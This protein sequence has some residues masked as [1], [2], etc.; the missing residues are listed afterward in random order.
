MISS[1]DVQLPLEELMPL[2][3][4]RLEMGQTV[5]FS[6]RGTSML[7]MLRQGTDTITLSPLPE[8]LKK[9]DIPL[10]RRENGQ[11]VLHRIVAVGQRFTCMGDNQFSA[12]A[13][14]GRS[15]MI[16]IVTGFSRGEKQWSVR[17]PVYG[18]YCR[19]WHY[20]RPLRRL[21]RRG[22]GLFRRLL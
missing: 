14:V 4:E 16:G 22:A 3:R 9:Y 17:H 13:N 12:E 2:I 8:K 6:P 5:C 21:W 11:Y 7:P 19:L 1:R 15:Q 20:S 18:L 10:Y